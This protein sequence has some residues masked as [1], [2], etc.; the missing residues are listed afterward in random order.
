[1]SQRYTHSSWR[2]CSCCD[3]CSCVRLDWSASNGLLRPPFL[4]QLIAAAPEIRLVYARRGVCDAAGTSF[5]VALHFMALSK[6]HLQKAALLQAQESSTCECAPR[7][8]T[9]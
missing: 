1:M 5:D 9:Q 3:R 2:W 7:A 6:V 8:R 4:P